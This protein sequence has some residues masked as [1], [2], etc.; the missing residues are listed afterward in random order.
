ME[1]AYLYVR[2]STDEQKRKGYSLPEQED[3]LLKYCGY[4]GV[5]VKGIFR[6]DY[7]AK[8]FNRPEWKRLIA[9]VK[10]NRSDERNNI[11]FLKWDRFSRNIE[12][13]YEMIGILRRHNTTAMAIDQPIDFSV[14]ESTVMLA[15][16]LSIPEAENS[17]KSLNVSS[18]IRRAK[19]MGRYPGRAP[20]G[21][22]NLATIDGRKY[23]APKQQEA[24]IVAWAFG[25]LARNC[26]TIEEVR[27]MAVAK[28]M[29]CSKS[30]FWQ[31]IRNPVYCGFVVLTSETE[32]HQLIRALHQP[33]ISESLFYEVQNIIGTKKRV[34]GKND[35]LK[36]AF[37]LKGYL[38]CPI[39][40]R[41]L[42]GSFSSGRTKK[43]PYYHCSGDC[44]A[45]FR[46]EPLNKS[47]IERLQQLVLLDGAIDLFALVLE[48]ANEGI[49]KARYLNER[50][51]LLRQL[52]EQESVISKAR[53][54]F[55]AGLLNFDDFSEIKREYRD[56][57]G[58][59]KKELDTV[60]V[61][62]ARIDRRSKI[63]RRSL[64]NIFSEFPDMD[65][66]NKKLVVSMISP[67]GVDL[68]TGNISLLPNETISKIFAPM[69][70]LPLLF[71]QTAQHLVPMTTTAS[72]TSHFKDR[73]VSIERAT[74]ILT[75]TGVQVED[76]EVAAILDF[77]YH[78]A[79]TREWAGGGE[80]HREP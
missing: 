60:V 25:Q 13:A 49:Q 36:S 29:K 4:N 72:G 53:K 43:Y 45:R 31:L 39:C 64:A 6:E 61:Q 20:K 73:K 22:A 47:Y 37:I 70:Q 14:P 11:L 15:V 18:A 50:Q 7:S 69:G 42:R 34:V 30:Y 57:S 66:A 46:A 56:V 28:G 23:I 32:G 21:F 9:T 3:R 71:G 44:R 5:E 26:Y 54:L 51:R 35:E 68:S 17:R 12:Y 16:Y 75:K 76:N 41:K 63:A 59:L 65:I 67:I 78:I 2:V 27:R 52:E 80:K 38:D 48:D 1:T 19:Q 62:L 79:K 58:T 55:V 8:N 33:L 77:L 74:A 40:G 10:K 24:A